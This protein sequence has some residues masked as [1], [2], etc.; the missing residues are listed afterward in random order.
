MKKIIILILCCGVFVSMVGC[1]GNTASPPADDSPP[2][3]VSETVIKETPTETIPLTTAVEP[4][5]KET[6]S[7]KR[8]KQTIEPT[9]TTPTTTEELKSS[10]AI[11]TSEEKVVSQV[12]ETVASTTTQHTEMEIATTEP[13]KEAVSEPKII[14]AEF[15]INYWITFAKEYAVSVGLALESEAVSCWDNPIGAGAHCIYLERD[16]KSRLNRYAKD[17][18]ITDVWIW[19]EPIG[20]DCYDIYIGYA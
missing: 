1:G 7:I 18:E 16:I 10:E 12:M 9:S 19:V 3:M 20:D 14:Q 11:N 6:V 5:E 8:Q 4:T 17:E 15:D 13:T 2:T